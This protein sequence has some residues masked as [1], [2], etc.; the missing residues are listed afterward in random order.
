M[1]R[2]A[3]L[4][5][6]TAW[7]LA[8]AF[9]VPLHAAP[10]RLWDFGAGDAAGWTAERGTLTVADGNVRLR[11]DANRRVVLLSP[12]SSADSNEAAGEF[13]VGVAG[14]G[15]VRVRVQGRRDE[16]GGWIT[17]AD[18]RGSALRETPAGVAVK[19]SLMPGAAYERLRIELEFRT[20][21]ART[22]ERIAINP[23]R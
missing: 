15:L 12:P 14:T 13:V 23:A 2:C 8:V 20:T 16:R 4:P 21:N 17:L 11:P 10:L 18:A 1:R 3:W 6:G 9:A 19:R 7:L 5:R 22:L